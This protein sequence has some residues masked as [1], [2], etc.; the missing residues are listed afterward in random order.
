[1]ALLPIWS[2][3]EPHAFSSDINAGLAAEVAD[4]LWLML[5]QWQLGELH[6]DDS[7]SP[8]AVDIS[9]SHTPFTRYRLGSAGEAQPLDRVSGPLEAVVE[10]EPEIRLGGWTPWS[11]TVRAGRRLSRI[12]AED[13]L[14]DVA[15]RFAGHPST[16]F[17]AA[18]IEKEPPPEEPEHARAQAPVQGVEDHRYRLLLA[19][20]GQMIDGAEVLKMVAEGPIAT[21]IIGDADPDAVVAAVARWSEEMR[22]EWGVTTESPRSPAWDPQRMEYAFSIAAPALPGDEGE[23]VLRA[24]EYDGTGVRW[25]SV[26]LEPDAPPH[27]AAGDAGAQTRV[28]SMLPT[29]LRYAGMPADRFWEFEDAA[30]ALGRVRSGPTDLVKMLAVDFAIVYSPDWHLVP[31]EVPVG[32]IA[33]IDWIVVRDTFGVATLVGT[34]ASQAADGAGRLFQPANL[35]GEGDNPVLVVVPSALGMLTSEPLEEVA[36]QRDEMA[37][38]AWSIEKLVLG[39]SGRPVPREWFPAEFDLPKATSEK[40]H[41]LVWRLATRVASPWTPLVAVLDEPGILRRARIL[42]T[43][44][45]ELRSAQS[46]LLAGEHDV[47]DEEVTRAGLQLRMVQQRAR[48]SDGSTV[49]WRSREKRSWKGEASSG[50]QFDAATPATG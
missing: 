28:R 49:V 22:I 2:R 16:Q 24:A 6:G 30:V 40:P 32:S 43:E 10:R 17:N 3:V 7:G 31:V 48:T 20:R 46:L 4:P 26:D 41:E 47:K 13:G 50:L 5:R 35:V 39:P 37:N 23:L 11:V 14:S 34:T 25:D 9:V 12:L 15:T 36:L 38:L 21:E 45:T 44:S 19:D 33:R 1:M 29:A 18:R 8:A 27:G 42:D